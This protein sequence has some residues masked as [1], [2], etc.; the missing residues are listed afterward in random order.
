MTTFDTQGLR[1]LGVPDAMVNFM[2]WVVEQDMETVTTVLACIGVI[3][4]VLQGRLTISTPDGRVPHVWAMEK[5]ATDL[6]D[7]AQGAGFVEVAQFCEGARQGAQA[8]ITL[9][10]QG[11]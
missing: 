2:E 9:L 11:L 10:Q 6:R 8:V 1:E 4:D 7:I 5:A 3:D